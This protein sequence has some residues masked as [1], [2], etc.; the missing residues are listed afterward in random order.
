MGVYRGVQ[1]YIGY[2][3]GRR[4]LLAGFFTGNRELNWVAVQELHLGDYIGDIL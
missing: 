1:G 3:S 2:C 4:S